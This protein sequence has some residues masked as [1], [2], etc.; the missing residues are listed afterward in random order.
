MNATIYTNATPATREYRLMYLWGAWIT[1]EII[2]AESDAE[3]VFD[4]D[5]TFAASRL[6]GWKHGVALFCGNRKVKQYV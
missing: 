6:Q 1:K 2:C 5:T 4:A 3:A